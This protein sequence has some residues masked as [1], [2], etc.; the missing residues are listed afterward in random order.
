VVTL[1][2]MSCRWYRL[3]RASLL[4]LVSL[5]CK[6]CRSRL[7]HDV[8]LGGESSVVFTTCGVPQMLQLGMMMGY[9]PQQLTS[10]LTALHTDQVGDTRGTSFLIIEPY[11]HGRLAWRLTKAICNTPCTATCRCQWVGWC[12]QH[13]SHRLCRCLAHR[14]IIWGYPD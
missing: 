13:Q 12:S 6:E 5:G 8:L 9:H 3:P 2:L 11:R 10:L 7:E 1:P 4:S 14:R